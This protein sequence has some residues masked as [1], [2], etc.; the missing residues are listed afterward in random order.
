MLCASLPVLV[1]LRKNDRVQNP[2]PVTVA[3]GVCTVRVSPPIWLAV[4]F[5]IP[6][7]VKGAPDTCAQ[8]P[9]VHPEKPNDPSKFSVNAGDV[10]YA[11]T[12]PGTGSK[13]QRAKS[14]RASRPGDVGFAKEAQH[15]GRYAVERLNAVVVG[16]GH[17]DQETVIGGRSV[18]TVGV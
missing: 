7:E 9:L 16:V 1:S 17:Y 5:V 14:W 8:P 4:L 18:Q 15:G 10:V 12:K 3:E 6:K 2:G 11:T 13:Q